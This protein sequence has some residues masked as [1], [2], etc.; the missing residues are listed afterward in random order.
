VHQPLDTKRMRRALE[1]LDA[2]MEAPARLVVGGG[3]A[4]VL[5]YD[6]PIATQDVDDLR[7]EAGK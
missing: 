3:A 2:A 7:D 5:A 1:L 6:H 4:M